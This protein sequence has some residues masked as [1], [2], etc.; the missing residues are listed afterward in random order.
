M[1]GGYV[2][3]GTRVPSLQGVYVYGDACSGKVWG[4]T[5]AGG[6]GTGQQELDL[7]GVEDAVATSG[8]NISSF[9]EDGAG[10]LYLLSLGGGV[11]RFEPV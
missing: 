6:E 4:L 3:R 2:Y 7:P 8:F 10:E 11:Y 5:Q 1:T 9:G